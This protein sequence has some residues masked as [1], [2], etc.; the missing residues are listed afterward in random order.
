MPRFPTFGSARDFEDSASRRRHMLSTRHIE[1]AYDA[2]KLI[3]GS[4]LDGW[5]LGYVGVPWPGP[6]P[7]VNGDLFVVDPDG[8]QAGIA[9]ESSGPEVCEIS[10]ASATRWGVYQ[11]RFPLPVMSERDLVRNF[12]A[13]LPMLRDLRASVAATRASFA[14][15]GE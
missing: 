12:V 1:D 3:E 4:L 7:K 10:S 15:K 13:V 6:W 9:W 11:I 2:A 5:A 14:L 8:W